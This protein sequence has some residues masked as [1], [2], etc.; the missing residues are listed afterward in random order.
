MPMHI[1]PQDF[2]FSTTWAS[3][4]AQ[5]KGAT[6]LLD[7]LDSVGL[8]RLE[9][10]YKITTPLLAKL[11]PGMKAGGFS[12][13]SV[14]N[15]CPLPGDMDPDMA[16]GDLFNLASLDKEERNQAVKYTIPTLELASDL[17]APA[18]VMHL[19]WIAGLED[20]EVIHQPAEDGLPSKSMT[21]HLA[22]RAELSP[23][24][25]D[26]VSFTLERL[27]ERASSLGVTLGVENR[28]HAFQVPDLEETS[29]LL[30]RFQGGPIAHWHDLGH[31]HTQA[32]AGL[33]G[34]T[35]WLERFDGRTLG[36]H[37]HDCQGTHDHQLPGQGDIPW[38]DLAPLI[39][40]LSHKVLELHP[41]PGP[42]EIREGYEYLAKVL[43]QT[44]G[45]QDKVA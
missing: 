30:D 42:E 22:R 43:E 14:H 38:Q 17:E 16:S 26:A 2:S 23:R 5:T 18:V 6:W 41:G 9:L 36:C 28:Y 40:P 10:E 21:S 1:S 37:V 19:G 11:V 15:F 44:A 27:L 32:F 25:L 4:E 24:H 45:S 3:K 33:P 13:R 12:V 20:R 34:T 35:A 31:G 29:L 8:K 39:A 7:Q